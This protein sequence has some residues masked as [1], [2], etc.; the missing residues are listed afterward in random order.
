MSL[1]AR[2]LAIAQSLPEEDVPR[3]LRCAS[4]SKL[5][6]DAAKLLCCDETLCG[7]CQ[8]SAMDNCPRCGLV[9]L[10]HGGFRPNKP[11]RDAVKAFA[12]RERKKRRLVNVHRRGT[13]QDRVAE[14]RVSRG[15][16]KSLAE[17]SV[18]KSSVVQ[19][20]HESSVSELSLAVLS[21][22]EDSTRKVDTQLVPGSS[23]A[24][25][26]SGDK[27]THPKACL[28]LSLPGEL[29][30]MI[31]DF[32]YPA[33]G[34]VKY[35]NR[36]Q[37]E[38]S[39]KDKRRADPAVYTPRDFPE[40]SVER[41]L[42]C[43]DFFVAAS[44]AW[45][46]NQ[47]FHARFDEAF[48]TLGW[49]QGTGVVG[50]FVAKLETRLWVT[51]TNDLHLYDN[52][53]ELELTVEVDTFEVLGP[54]FA[55]VE[56]LSEQDLNTIVSSNRLSLLRGLRILKLVP[57]H[58]TWA[59]TKSKVKTWKANVRKLEEIVKPIATAGR[60]TRRPSETNRTLY[61]GSKVRFADPP[62]GVAGPRPRTLASLNSKTIVVR[63]TG[64]AL[65]SKQTPVPALPPTLQTIE[66]A[67]SRPA[68]LAP[69]DLKTTAFITNMKALVSKEKSV[70]TLPR[71]KQPVLPV[72]T[73]KLTDMS[74][75]EVADEGMMPWVQRQLS[76]ITIHVPPQL[77]IADALSYRQSWQRTA[78]ETLVR[79]FCATKAAGALQLQIQRMLAQGQVPSQ[80]MTQQHEAAKR[81]A[82][83][84]NKAWEVM[85]RQ[86][87]DNEQ[88]GSP[89]GQ[90]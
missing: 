40:V 25:A 70:R 84:T 51:I 21:I 35:V 52:L 87:R 16:E 8:S 15:I 2:S 22:A 77:P 43:K 65:L 67:G 74:K 28:L 64:K 12:M 73:L 47:T 3:R 63:T 5:A 56:E 32:A 34:D 78:D 7:A 44:R 26:E 6:V 66:V 71:I 36:K 89:D 79:L 59:D 17:S 49:G 81:T 37:W 54:K 83:M 23:G 75:K 19:S 88:I 9:L 42:A 80:A 50:A 38:V 27:S 20:D 90:K 41:F 13:A 30:D 24:A 68:A 69:L 29:Q 58:C 46:S 4:C 1:E 85:K 62:T 10:C 61:D 18:L 11:V 14:D 60:E 45:V 53:R 33:E 48:V 76:S 82:E 39:E 55:W 72:Y 31:F 86:D 57:G